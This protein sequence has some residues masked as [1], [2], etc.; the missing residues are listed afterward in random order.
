[1][2]QGQRP[3]EKPRKHFHLLWC[4]DALTLTGE[5]ALPSLPWSCYTS[6]GIPGPVLGEHWF[7]V[8]KVGTKQ[9]TQQLDK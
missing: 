5:R 8:G 1:M 2:L 9:N 7:S 4:L 6:G 3:R